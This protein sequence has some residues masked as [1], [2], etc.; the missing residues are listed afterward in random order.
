MLLVTPHSS[1]DLMS[2]TGPAYRIICSTGSSRWSAYDDFLEET[3]QLL[4]A[5]VPVQVHES[6]WFQH[7]GAPTHFAHRVRSWLD[8]DFPD[9]WI[10]HGGPIA[11]PPHSPD[12]TP[13]FLFAGTHE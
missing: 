12:L 3:L 2:T 13:I 8:N 1:T 4:V 11:W 7:D 6:M 10:G 9:R 5:N